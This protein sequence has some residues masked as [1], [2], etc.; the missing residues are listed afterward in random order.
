MDHKIDKSYPSAPLL[1]NFG[2]EK[3]IRKENK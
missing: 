1:E 3:T 2:L